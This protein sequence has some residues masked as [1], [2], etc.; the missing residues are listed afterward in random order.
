MGGRRVHADVRWVAAV[1]RVPVGPGRGAAGVRGRDGVFVLASAACGLAPGLGPLV[2]ARFVQ[3]A[4]AAAMMPSSMALVGHAYADPVSARP[5][6]GAVVDGRG[7][8]LYFRA[9]PGRPAD[10][11]SW[12]LIFFVNVPAG[13][14]GLRCWRGLPGRRTGPRAVRL[15][16]AGRRG[17][18][19]W[20]A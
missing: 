7:G 16:R 20:L 3:G 18:W 13:V 19:P 15:G 12:R 14:A 9:D 17:R 1:V 10:A 11:V 6:G 5:G 2:A 4:A 8:G